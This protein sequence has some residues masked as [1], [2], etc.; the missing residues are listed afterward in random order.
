[1]FNK[2]EQKA[3]T[4]FLQNFVSSRL[5]GKRIWL[6]DENDAPVMKRIFFGMGLLEPKYDCE[7]PNDPDKIYLYKP[8]SFGNDQNIGL[9]LSLA[10]VE[11]FCET[12]VPRF[13]AAGL[14]TKIEGD[15]INVRWFAGGDIEE[16]LRPF[17]MRAYYE[18]Y[19][20]VPG[21]NEDPLIVPLAAAA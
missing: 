20:V 9:I 11:D 13:I 4:K 18:F 16:I 3:M 1:M 5:F 12:I 19:N 15:I 21:S 10:G 2:D 6:A 8:T 17:V 14:M 7:D